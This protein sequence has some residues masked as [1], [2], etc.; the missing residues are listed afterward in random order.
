MPADFK[1][2]KSGKNDARPELKACHAFLEAGD[3]LVVP[4]LD[5]ILEARRLCGE[6]DQND[7][8]SPGE[9]TSVSGKPK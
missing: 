1:E 9:H 3:S 8:E 5:R 6:Q 2:K 7:A 4:S